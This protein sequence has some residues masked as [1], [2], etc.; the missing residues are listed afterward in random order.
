[1]DA[2][3]RVGP[4][5]DAVVVRVAGGERG[6]AGPP[7]AGSTYTHTQSSPAA[8]WQI[9][10]GLGRRPSVVTVDSLD[11]VVVGD[12]RYI[13]ASIVEVQFSAAFSGAAYLN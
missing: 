5:A 3:I 4:V 2:V 9:V 8:L 11:R 10:H 12:V 13:S 1:V 6:P 7:G